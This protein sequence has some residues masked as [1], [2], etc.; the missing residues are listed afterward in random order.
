[1]DRPDPGAGEH[2][3]RNLGDHRQVDR[4]AVAFSHAPRLQNIGKPAHRF[5]QFSVGDATGITGIVALPQD[6]GLLR[7]AP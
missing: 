5:V 1:V 4:D 7:A 2:G 6:R 3:H